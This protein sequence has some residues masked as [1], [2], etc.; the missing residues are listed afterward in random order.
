M[1]PKQ[2]TQKGKELL[3]KFPNA[4]KT[5]QESQR[6]DKDVLMDFFESVTTCAYG[7]LMFGH[8][9][10]GTLY[11]RA[12]GEN[13]TLREAIEYAEKYVCDMLNCIG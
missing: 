12:T 7:K 6:S 10:D 8:N 11:N 1:K 5:A 13:V 9:D 2:Y 4:E 3:A